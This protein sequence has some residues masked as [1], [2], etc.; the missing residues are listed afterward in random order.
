MVL[1]FWFG[2]RFC[3]FPLALSGGVSGEILRSSETPLAV[4]LDFAPTMLYSPSGPSSNSQP[5]GVMRSTFDLLVIRRT[6]TIVLGRA[7]SPY[8]DES[9]RDKSCV[10][11]M[12]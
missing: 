10:H 7:A 5:L 6:R 1:Y 9:P 11:V 12:D 3:S 8:C 4:V 2:R